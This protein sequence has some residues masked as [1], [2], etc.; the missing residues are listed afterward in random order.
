MRSLTFSLNKLPLLLALAALLGATACEH[1][2]TA[3]EIQA[4]KVAA[5]RNRQKAEA[6]KV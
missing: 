1:K 3:A 6:I 5:F 4:K 2:E